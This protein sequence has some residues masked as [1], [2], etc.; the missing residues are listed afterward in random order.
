MRTKDSY[1]IQNF[2]M[3][4]HGMFVFLCAKCFKETHKAKN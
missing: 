2:R 1:L 4:V 3:P